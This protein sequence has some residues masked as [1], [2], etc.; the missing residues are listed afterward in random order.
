MHDRAR[1]SPGE[2]DT[3]AL[4][5]LRRIQHKWGVSGAVTTGSIGAGGWTGPCRLRLPSALSSA[6]KA[7]SSLPRWLPSHLFPF[8]KDTSEM[9]LNPGLP[10]GLSSYTYSPA[11][12][13]LQT[14]PAPAAP[15]AGLL[16]AHPQGVLFPMALG[17]C[18]RRTHDVR[19]SRVVSGISILTLRS[20]VSMRPGMGTGALQTL[21]GPPS[22]A[23]RPGS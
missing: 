19:I 11:P 1:K 13:A 5:L 4:C 7:P 18:S 12:P 2:Q 16:L 17:P 21:Q 8:P 6:I 10:A 9:S 15:T 20:D 22:K 23:K 14:C 3:R